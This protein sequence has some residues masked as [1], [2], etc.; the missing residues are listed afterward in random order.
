M[1]DKIPFLIDLPTKEAYVRE[2]YE[3]MG[4]SSKLNFSPA[5]ITPGIIVKRDPPHVSAN[6]PG[7][8]GRIYVLGVPASEGQAEERGIGIPHTMYKTRHLYIE[9]VRR[10]FSDTPGLFVPALLM[11][12]DTTEELVTELKGLDE[13][14][15]ENQPQLV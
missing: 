1:T 8:I 7:G 9:L 5:G 13:L 12:L 11:Q 2:L 3:R 6:Y 15:F 10:G 14:I 4:N